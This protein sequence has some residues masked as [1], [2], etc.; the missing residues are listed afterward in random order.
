MIF[1]CFCLLLTVYSRE[2][3][4]APF[5]ASVRAVL[6]ALII[7]HQKGRHLC[8]IW[9]HLGCRHCYCNW[10]KKRVGSWC[11]HDLWSWRPQGQEM[12]KMGQT[13]EGSGA[14]QEGSKGIKLK[15]G[16]ELGS[17]MPSFCLVLLGSQAPLPQARRLESQA[18]P[19]L[20][21]P[22]LGVLLLLLPGFQWS[23][24]PLWP[25]GSGCVQQ[26]RYYYQICWDCGLSCCNQG[27]GIVDT[28]FS[29][30]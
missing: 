27:P 14:G 4:L 30:P 25:G 19:Q 20:E 23:W 12:V 9:S 26:L 28:A 15:R 22:E 5:T 1:V 2:L 17:W 10:K 21:G 24:A 29:V 16:Q 11:L 8:C 6:S 7:E 3:V 13:Q 18:P